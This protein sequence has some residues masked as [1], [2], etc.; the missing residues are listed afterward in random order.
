MV[1]VEQDWR[2]FKIRLV[3]EEIEITS[4]FCYWFCYV[5]DGQNRWREAELRASRWG[6][7]LG[8]ILHVMER[9]I[10]WPL[11]GKCDQGNR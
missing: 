7:G 9:I 10:C 1:R 8:K 11:G 4:V 6:Q 2:Y 5:W 3:D